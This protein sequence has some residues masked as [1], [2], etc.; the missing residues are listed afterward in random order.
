MAVL[1]TSSL[2]ANT[3]LHQLYMLGCSLRQFSSATVSR[4]SIAYIDNMNNAM[5]FYNRQQKHRNNLHA[6][7]TARAVLSTPCETNVVSLHADLHEQQQIL[8]QSLKKRG[9]SQLRT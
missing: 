6:N 9:K 4:T 1:I 2:P 7:N 3:Q 5:F 8:K